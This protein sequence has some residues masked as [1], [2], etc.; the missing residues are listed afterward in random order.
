MGIQS[1]FLNYAAEHGYVDLLKY[2]VEHGINLKLHGLYALNNAAYKGQ[3]ES[4]KFLVNHGIE[5]KAKKGMK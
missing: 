3:L 2:A 1:P 4:I 5:I